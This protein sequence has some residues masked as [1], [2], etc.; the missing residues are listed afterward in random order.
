M[1][2][3]DSQPKTKPKACNY[4]LQL[5]TGTF[6]VIY[7]AE[8]RPDPDQLKKAV[9]AFQRSPP[10]VACIQAKL[11]YFNQDQN[12]LT[13][14]FATEY[15]M[16]F[17]LVLPAMDAAGLADPA[18]RHLQPLHTSVLR[19][20]GAWDPFNVTE[21]ADLGIRLHRRATAPR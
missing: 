4:G 8:D 5:A 14:W 12:L 10:N 16:Y 17:D 3:P 19:E 13:R 11:N 15:S 9:L 20:L 18:R 2:V 21:D 6:C 1:V 7:D